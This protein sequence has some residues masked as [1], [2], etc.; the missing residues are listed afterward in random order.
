[1]IELTELECALIEYLLRTERARVATALRLTESDGR[2]IQLARRI[3]VAGSA[4][5]KIT[6]RQFFLEHGEK[7]TESLAVSDAGDDEG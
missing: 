6:Q 3:E 5:E 7:Q 4:I 2:R 1:M